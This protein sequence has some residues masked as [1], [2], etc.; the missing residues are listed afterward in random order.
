MQVFIDPGRASG[1]PKGQTI[2]EL[3][4][5]LDSY[6]DGLAGVVLYVNQRGPSLLVTVAHGEPELQRLGKARR[7]SKPPVPVLVIDPEPMP[8]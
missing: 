2:S 4:I 1:N 8:R 6:G 5:E 7:P 3:R